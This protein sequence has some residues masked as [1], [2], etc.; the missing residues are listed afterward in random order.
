MYHFIAG[1]TSKM[2]GTEMGVT[3]PSAT[4]SSCYGA[5]FLAHHPSV[6]ADML[7]KKLKE[8]SASAWLINTGWVGG[9]A[10]KGGEGAGGCRCPLRYTRAIV[11][12]IHDGSLLRPDVPYRTTPV[13]NL[14]V[15]TKAAVVPE[16]ILVPELCW[17]N[18]NAYHAQLKKLATLFIENFKQYEDVCSDDVHKA[19]PSL[20]N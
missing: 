14:S 4:F 18:R 15:P 20:V 3:E 5:P 11:D 1:Y 2:A 7:A 8:H 19:G 13:F 12:A 16:E 9:S 10:G 6:Y 17:K